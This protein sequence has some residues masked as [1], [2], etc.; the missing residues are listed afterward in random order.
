M[1]LRYRSGDVGLN[2]TYGGHGREK[3]SAFRVIIKILAFSYKLCVAVAFEASARLPS[4][5]LLIVSSTFRRPYD[6]T[7]IFTLDFASSLCIHEVKKIMR[8]HENMSVRCIPM[9]YFQPMKRRF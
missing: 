1:A 2:I 8:P 6:R 5:L 3:Q 4:L 7:C 9:M